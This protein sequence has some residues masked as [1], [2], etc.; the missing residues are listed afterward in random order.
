MK[1][2]ADRSPGELSD[3]D[4]TREYPEYS[5]NEDVSDVE[6]GDDDRPPHSRKMRSSR[7]TFASR[8]ST[9]DVCSSFMQSI[10]SNVCIWAVV[11]SGV[12]HLFTCFVHV[13]PAEKLEAKICCSATP[14]QSL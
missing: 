3:D 9:C 7:P 2:L 1:N 13:L 6:A 11:Y 4:E 14:I 8:V 12:M 10:L 5:S